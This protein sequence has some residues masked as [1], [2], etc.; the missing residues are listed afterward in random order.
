M[1]LFFWLLLF[2]ICSLHPMSHDAKQCCNQL[3]VPNSHFERRKRRYWMK[4]VKI[5]PKKWH[6]WNNFEVVIKNA[7]NFMLCPLIIPLASF[8]AVF[9]A[10]IVYVISQNKYCDHIDLAENFFWQFRYV[11]D[12]YILALNRNFYN[13]WKQKSEIINIRMWHVVCSKKENLRVFFSLL[14]FIL[15]LWHYT[16]IIWI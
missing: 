2:F 7:L 3:F 15:L 12:F 6:H 1:H 5:A 11:L 10:T 14:K 4:L 13:L 9:Y 16:W 8:T